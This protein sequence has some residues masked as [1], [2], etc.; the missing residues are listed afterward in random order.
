MVN[1][2][3]ARV[4]AELGLIVPDAYRHFL[5]SVSS[6]GFDLARFR[7]CHDTE[8]ILRTNHIRR[9]MLGDAE[10]RWCNNFLDI[11]VGDGCGNYFFLHANAISD[12]TVQ[13]WAHD[14]PGIDD[15]STATQ[16]FAEL[17]AELAQD[18]QGP[19]KYRFDGSV[20]TSLPKRASRENVINPFTGKP[21]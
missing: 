19:N 2:D 17:L 5:S 14:P 18:F 8:T 3:F 13:L 4:E 6:R 16:F 1:I 7:I 21:I 15:V 20:I 11:G 9:E 12:D 10:P